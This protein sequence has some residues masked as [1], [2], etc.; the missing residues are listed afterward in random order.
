MEFGIRVSEGVFYS[1]IGAVL[2]SM[3]IFFSLSSFARYDLVLGYITWPFDILQLASFWVVLYV[4]DSWVKTSRPR[5]RNR[6]LILLT[7]SVFLIALFCIQQLFVGDSIASEFFGR[8]KVSTRM[9]EPIL[10]KT[11]SRIAEIIFGNSL[12]LDNL[13]AAPSDFV[14]RQW[15]IT[16]VAFLVLSQPQLKWKTFRKR[17]VQASFIFTFLFVAFARYARLQA[18]PLDIAITLGV[19]NIMVWPILFLWAEAGSTPPDPD[20]Y[21]SFVFSSFILIAG[22][23]T[24]AKDP[25]WPFVW[26]LLILFAPLFFLARYGLKRV[27]RS[28]NKHD[29][30]M[31]SDVF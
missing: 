29:G 10:T 17:I 5:F 28:S 4:I 27:T 2:L 6:V 16:L 18:A 25:T 22:F 30:L 7:I 14:L 11:V 26:Y 13:N 15:T 19:G 3:I 20:I 9:E 23:A 31:T 1:S 21:Y 24:I 12:R 8:I